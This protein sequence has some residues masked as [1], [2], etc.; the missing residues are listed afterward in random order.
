[1][2][3]LV[4]L[5]L[6]AGVSVTLLGGCSSRQASDETAGGPP[7]PIEEVVPV[8][9]ADRSRAGRAAALDV[10]A[11]PM[12]APYSPAPPREHRERYPDAGDNPVKVA[13]EEPVS[14][15]SIDVDTASYGN[16]RRLLG[17][18][19][20]PPAD[21]VRIEELINYFR[22]DYPAPADGEAFRVVTEVG[23]A[24]WHPGRRLLHIG[25]RG[26][27]ID[28]ADLPPANLV[29]LV[30]VS[31]SMDSPQK[32]DLVKAS[33][34]LLARQLDADDRLS[35]AVYAGAAGTAL[36]P[37]PGDRTA[38]IEAAIDRL[39]PGGSTYGEAGIRLAYA[40][41]RQAYIEGG[42]NRVILATDGDFN[43]GV[44]SVDE[45]KELVARERESGVTLTV[46]GF[47]SGNYNDALM[48]ALA[49][50]G[51]GNAAYVDSFNEA[52]KV[53]VEELGAT[54]SVIAKD[55]KVQVEF[56]PAVVAEYRLLGYETRLLAR[57]DFN[58]DRVDAGEIGAGHTVTALYELTLRGSDARRI[59]PLRYGSERPPASGRHADE[60]ALVRLRHKE[61]TGRTSRLQEIPVRVADMRDSLAET[62]DDF[63]F[64][65]AVAAFGTLLRGGTAVESFGYDDVIELARDA[66]GSDP[67]GYRSEFLGLARSAAALAGSPPPSPAVGRH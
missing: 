4:L 40:L 2:H 25:L 17:H 11:T 64:S 45:L 19:V 39:Q 51:N 27:S 43:V 18:G 3:R 24:P 26:A 34:K 60:L 33:M 53:L 38:A 59:D 41:A 16:V 50:T 55:V 32:I 66:R 46:L 52:R 22:Y 58:N 49:Q 35:I 67:D 63:R 13:A 65:A 10:I 15:F 29:F 37:T 5:G 23:P 48:Q 12:P 36:E 56:N 31:G 14:T 54:L 30:D 6:A 44:T 20:L 62:R 8:G 42:I 1:M 21:A 47:G 9:E 7:A 61:P 57:E 28:T